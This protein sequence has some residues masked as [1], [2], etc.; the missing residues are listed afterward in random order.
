M[1][2]NGKK[3]GRKKKEEITTAKIEDL[4]R[5]IKNLLLD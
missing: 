3:E 4:R 5:T 2:P 1:K